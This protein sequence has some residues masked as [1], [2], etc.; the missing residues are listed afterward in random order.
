VATEYLRPLVTG[1][2]WNAIGISQVEHLPI[3]RLARFG[4]VYLISAEVVAVSALLALALRIKERRV[5]IAAVGL[6]LIGALTLM[7]PEGEKPQSG[8]EIT[9]LGIQPNLAPDSIDTSEA[10]T[11]SF[12]QNIRLTREGIERVP[13]RSV[14]L[15][16]WA[17]SPLT[18]FY[19]RDPDLRNRLDSLARETGS[20]F[21][22]NTIAR[23]GENY[24]NSVQTIGPETPDRPAAASFKRYDKVRLVPFGEYVPW[25]AVLGIFVPTIVGDFTPGREA[26]VNT[27]KLKTQ[28]AAII[29][30]SEVSPA[31][32]LERTTNFL[33]VGAFICYE[34]AYQDLVRQFAKNG[35]TLLVNVSNDAWFG[36]TAGPRQHLRHAMMRAIENDRDLLRVTNTGISALIT[37]D[38]Q[39][40]DPLPSFTPGA[41]AWRAQARRSQTFY[42]RHGDWFASGCIGFSLLIFLSLARGSKIG[43]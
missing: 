40:V 29:S 34:A 41:R 33:R 42:T 13:D 1:V 9:A 31:P 21:M 38:G 35:A 43:R 18:I 5:A 39:V 8:P 12:E 23:D 3:S 37:A 20:Y 36:D 6:L 4:G 26:V 17:E 14:D 15:V 16:I 11:T 22:I 19:E 24:F 10:L 25:R 7:L 30:E 2:T 27:L 28:R 32:A